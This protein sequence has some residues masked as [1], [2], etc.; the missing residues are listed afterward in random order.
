[1]VVLL[2]IWHAI[3]HLVTSA[4]PITIVLGLV[5]VLVAGLMLKGIGNIL[6]GTV[7]ALIGFAVLKYLAAI[8]LD[9]QS[10]GAFAKADWQAFLAI[11]MVTLL[12]YLIL[13]GVLIAVVHFI[14]SAVAR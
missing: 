12:A 13:F 2:D 3:Q 7:L 5:A 14:R 11:D 9:K 6:N 10:P 8:L 1:M 4:G